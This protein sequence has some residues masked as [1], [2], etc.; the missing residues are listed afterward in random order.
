[1]ASQLIVQAPPEKLRRL[2]ELREI[3]R[4]QE[5]VRLAKVD[6]F[7]ALGYEPTCKPRALA[8]LARDRGEDVP[9]PEPCG[10]C[11]QEQFHA[12]T[13]D[14]VLYGGAAGGG[15]TLGLIM[16]G[17][18]ACIRHPGIRVLI[19][20]RTYDELAESIYPEFQRL[21]WAAALG[22]RWNKTEKEL[23]FPNGSVIRCRYLESIED[24]SRRQGGAYQLLL[25]DELT[26][27]PPG[28]VDLVALERLRSAHG[29]PVLGI[30]AASNPGGPSHG[31][32]RERYI[33][34]TEHGRIVA[35][36]DNGLTRRFI[37]AKAT[38]NPYLDAAYFRR[39][40]A[41]T[42]PARRAAMRDGDWGQFSGQMFQQYRWD[43]HT[44]DPVTLPAAWRRYNGVDWGFAA[45]WAVLWGAEDEDK[46]VWIYREIYETQ[47]GEAEQA[48]RILAAE[49][50]DERVLV[51]WADD[52]MWATRGD[53]KPIS[54]V[55]A[56]N[57]CHITPAGKGPGSRI[58]GWQRWHSYL[59]EAPACPHH[60]AAGWAT[61][62]KIH[63]F[64][65]CPKLIHELE[66]L[67]YAT[68]GNVEDADPKAKDHAM[69]AGRYLLLNLGGGP[70]FTVFPEEQVNP[71]AEQIGEP[72]QPLGPFAVRPYADDDLAYGGEY[73]EQVQ[74]I[75]RTV[76]TVE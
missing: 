22:G 18:R 61:C 39:L 57:G 14:S 28:A 42:D 24:A 76:R 40:D 51:R 34:A 47:V 50:D 38:D 46:R 54:T 73:E 11:P 27:M 68:T 45:P 31:E 7:A 35:V 25:V 20:R 44:I 33:D 72:L 71:V 67:P 48:T 58:A 10:R 70:E 1:M 16:E 75:V 62:P 3:R 32:V 53:A 59:A 64:R 52:A 8:R 63:I 43:R 26:L 60:R 23:T 12:A 21:G 9:V 13:E 5:A 6:A 41:I 15:K 56:E 49:A 37:P 66:N 55:Y 29:I 19:L 65:T 4:K 36:D 30:R 74:R 2:R 17:I 69:D